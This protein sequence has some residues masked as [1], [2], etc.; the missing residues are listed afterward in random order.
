MKR[1]LLDWLQI[2]PGMPRIQAHTAHAATDDNN[3]ELGRPWAPEHNVDQAALDA[4]M[5]AQPPKSTAE[6]LAL[7][8]KAIEPAVGMS[9]VA[10][11]PPARPAPE[12]EPIPADDPVP[13][14]EIGRPSAAEFEAA[15]E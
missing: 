13:V 3:H 2:H 11:E 7:V 15:A 4:L 10:Q 1:Q 14:A 9:V 5:A 6:F 8:G 12:P